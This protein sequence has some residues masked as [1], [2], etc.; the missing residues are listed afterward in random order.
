MQNL[1]DSFH[2]HLE[3]R[4]ANSEKLKIDAHRVRYKVYCVERGYEDQTK[5][6]D[7]LE[8]DDF[9]SE[10]VHAVVRHRA[11]K[12]SVGVVRLV[13]PNPKNPNR[14][15]PI[16]THFGHLLEKHTLGRF[17]FNRHNIGEVS[18]FAVSKQS[19]KQIHD[20]LVSERLH[21]RPTIHQNDPKQLLPHI[22]LGLIAT[23]FAISREHGIDYWYAAMEPSLSRLLTRLG[24]DFV[25][26]GP[27]M[28]YHGRRL[29][30]IARVS[31][32]LGNIQ[33]SRKDFFKL[34]TDV[35]GAPTLEEQM[36]R[37]ASNAEL[38]EVNSY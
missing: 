20:R 5:F 29:P 33:R 8:K 1:S 3:A 34:I 19:L 10:S 9:D 17:K 25:P 32:L 35:G 26:I 14:K 4:I 36:E 11:S 7:R 2:M 28:D 27:I 30:M 6:P 24:I 18:R 22:S 37:S 16:E 31:D 38:I 12:Q 23:L 13:L 21:T 15:F